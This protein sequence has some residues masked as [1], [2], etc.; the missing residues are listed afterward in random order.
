MTNSS[1]N[2]VYQVCLQYID[3]TR[4]QHSSVQQFISFIDDLKK[5]TQLLEFLEDEE[6]FNRLLSH[7]SCITFESMLHILNHID[8]EQ[9]LEAYCSNLPI[10][11]YLIDKQFVDYAYNQFSIIFS[12]LNRSNPNFNFKN[13][14]DYLEHT[15]NQQL[16]F[17]RISKTTKDSFQNSIATHKWTTILECLNF[18][19]EAIQ[20]IVQ[21]LKRDKKAQLKFLDLL[22]C[23]LQEQNQSTSTVEPN[24]FLSCSKLVEFQLQSMNLLKN[25]A[26]ENLL[27]F[28]SEARSH[29]KCS[30]LSRH[31]SRLA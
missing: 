2:A 25:S 27:Q 12:D 20:S 6:L 18:D 24:A 30:A 28:L 31:S 11:H 4:D 8:S 10:L 14:F 7:Y 1:M 19:S 17:E 15:I 5:P 21:V 9:L 22:E 13:I 26:L 29:S 23:H 16:K 3:Q